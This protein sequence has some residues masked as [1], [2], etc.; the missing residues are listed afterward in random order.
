MKKKKRVPVDQKFPYCYS[1]LPISKKH[2][3]SANF[4]M[5]KCYEIENS[6]TSKYPDVYTPHHAYIINSILSS[7]TFLET[8]INEF[9]CSLSD[10]PFSCQIKKKITGKKLLR[11][12]QM[13]NLGIPRTASYSIPEKYQVA[14]ILSDKKPFSN[15]DP[16]YQ[17]ILTIKKLRNE[18]I[19][20]EPQL[21]EIFDDPEI[22]RKM[23][24]GVGK[25]LQ[26]ENFPLNPFV[27]EYMEFFP[28]RC[29]GY[30]CTKW[31]YDNSLNFVTEFENRMGIK[32]NATLTN[33]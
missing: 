23:M 19:H 33:S 32:S 15:Q 13:W 26:H 10:Y 27:G 24:T 3:A 4:F 30:G 25:Q 9:Y 12:Q 31:V 11:I 17:K 7:V 28:V 22:E 16:L 5:Q 14:L 21:K 1:W 20:Y 29:L 8:Y 2:L 18:L 6:K